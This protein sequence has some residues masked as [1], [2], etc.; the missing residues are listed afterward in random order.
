MPHAAVLRVRYSVPCG[1]APVSAGPLAAHMSPLNTKASDGTPTRAGCSLFHVL[2][3]TC[4]LAS[5]VLTFT[6]LPRATIFVRLVASV[7]AVLLSGVCALVAAVL[8]L[9]AVVIPRIAPGSRWQRDV[10]AFMASVFPG[11]W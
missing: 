4:A 9:T 2:I 6:L 1:T 8:L 7:A 5:G 11:K 10:D 3:F